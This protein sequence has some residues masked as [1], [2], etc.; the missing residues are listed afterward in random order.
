MGCR[1]GGVLS[2]CTSILCV[3]KEDFGEWW[4]KKS[5]VMGGKSVHT[6]PKLETL[7]LYGK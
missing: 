2:L 7:D 6:S 5:N 4:V 3:W 1:N